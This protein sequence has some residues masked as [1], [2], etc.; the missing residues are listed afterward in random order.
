M[1]APNETRVPPNNIDAER[2]VLS[3]ALLSRQAIADLET[4]L[5]ADDFYKP[6][7]AHIWNSVVSL[8]SLGEPVDVITVAEHLRADGLLEMVGGLPALTELHD[9]YSSSGAAARYGA[10][11]ARSARMRRLAAICTEIREQ[12]MGNPADS[13]SL[14]EQAAQAIYALAATR[15]DSRSEPSADAVSRVI[16][17][18]EEMVEHGTSRMGVTTGIAD[19]DEKLGG[20]RPGQLVTVCGRPG[21][22]KSILGAQSALNVAS[23]D[24]K[25]VLLVTVEMSVDEVSVRMLGAEGLVDLGHLKTGRLS[26]SDWPR[27]SRACETIGSAPLWMLDA[28][29]LTLSKI[30]NEVRR[31]CT[32]EPL[33]LVVVDYLQLIVPE[34]RRENRQVEVAEMSASLKRLAR[35][36]SVPVISLA[37]LNRSLEYRADKRPTL[38]DLRESGAI[39]NDSDVVIGIY[40]DEY[41][42]PDS[43]DAGTAELIILK[44][45]SGP[46]GTVRVG[47]LDNYGRF[48]N[49]TTGVV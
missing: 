36:F 33:G 47:W 13:D 16:A 38:A 23:S 35:D 43:A 32:H 6:A 11:V 21:M 42:H 12:A 29:S 25:P 49:L 45:R 46:L 22:G 2:A 48:A 37:Q 19:L 26:D 30:R 14:L 44:Q 34:N 28:S 3:A 15:E 27:L 31:L 20:L 40:R 7:H 18:I 24:R 4:M 9:I 17:Q 41:Y 5:A 39:E 10:I 1:T 8:A